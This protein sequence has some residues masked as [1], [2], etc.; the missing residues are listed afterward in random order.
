MNRLLSFFLAALAT[1]TALSQEHAPAPMMAQPGRAT[2]NVEPN[3]P[4]TTDPVR[5]YKAAYERA[6]KPRIAIFWDR[7]FTDQLSQW[8]SRYR[9]LTAGEATAKIESS[10]N[11]KTEPTA[12]KGAVNTKGAVAHYS[13]STNTVH[14]ENE[15]AHVE[16][17]AFAAAFAESLIGAGTT[18]VDRN[19]IMRLEAMAA[20][21]EATSMH[22]T[23]SQLIETSALSE[24][25]DYFL[26]VIFDEHAIA[27]AAEDVFRI[28]VKEVATGRVLLMLAS[29]AFPPA[30]KEALDAAPE[31]AP[32]EDGGFEKVYAEVPL[33]TSREMGRQMAIETMAA[34]GRVW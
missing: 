14:S 11:N 28:N 8:K 17:Y 10:K 23:D 7:K 2:T 20:N 34:L 3:S 27:R 16:D 12:Y 6:G 19:T 31:W 32:S 9:T 21:S 4:S 1:S 25:A 18:I 15:L 5:A 13:Q 26:E 24:Y 30:T 29:N 22:P 33:P